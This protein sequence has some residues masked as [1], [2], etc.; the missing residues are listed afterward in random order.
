M[1]LQRITRNRRLAP[2]EAAKYREVQERCQRILRAGL[3]ARARG[4]CC[5]PFG[6]RGCLGTVG[7]GSPRLR[8]SDPGLHAVA[9]LGLAS[10]ATPTSL[11]LLN[12]LLKRN[13]LLATHLGEV[14]GSH[15]LQFLH[16][17]EPGLIHLPHRPRPSARTRRASSAASCTVNVRPSTAL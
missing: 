9:P 5:R 17:I 3:R 10:E 4:R 13:G 1:T 14:V 6:A 16:L 2:E 12:S 11:D 7:P 8:R 15:G